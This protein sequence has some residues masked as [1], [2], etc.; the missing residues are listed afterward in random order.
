MTT[1]T[2]EKAG[3][4]LEKIKDIQHVVNELE[5]ISLYDPE[6]V[7]GTM[8]ERDKPVLLKVL[9]LKKSVNAKEEATVLLF[10]GVS[11]YGTR[12]PIDDELLPLLRAHFE[13]KLAEAKAE[14]ERLGGA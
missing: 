4:M 9:N 10:D 5:R 7:A 1:E 14:F 6:K 12:V 13:R 2:Y 11:A 8:Q 3:A